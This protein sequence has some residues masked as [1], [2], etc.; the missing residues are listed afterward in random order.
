MK[1]HVVVRLGDADNY[2]PAIGSHEPCLTV[3]INQPQ[4]P[5]LVGT[6]LFSVFKTYMDDSPRGTVA[7]LLSLAI[8]VYT[9]DLRISRG[10][11]LDRWTRELVLH[12]PVVDQSKWEHAVTAVQNMLGFLTGDSW[13]IELRERKETP[14]GT[15]K[16]LDIDGVCLFSGGA[17][18]LV[19][20]IDGLSQG[21][22]LALVGH[23]G[24]GMTNSF[25]QSTL[26]FLKK[27]YPDKIHPF[28]FYLQPPKNMKKSKTQETNPAFGM[29]GEN[30]M[31]SRSILFLALGVAVAE[32]AKNKQTL[33]VAENGLISLNVPLTNPRMGSL[34][35]RTTHP[36]FI[37]LF[38]SLLQKLHLRSTIEMPYQFKTKGE[39]FKEIGDQKVLQ[40]TLPL[41]MSCSHPEAGRYRGTFGKHCG[42]CVPC[43]IR[44]SAATAAKVADAQYTIDVRVNPP[45]WQTQ[46]GRDL[47]AFGMALERMKE[48]EPWDIFSDVMSTG[49]LPPQHI[50][51]YVAVFQRGMNE[52]ASFLT[53]KKIGCN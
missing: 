45:S 49:P 35:T 5:W 4:D 47:R 25:Q 38:R 29:E 1:W 18:S 33:M 23:H 27:R 15:T 21:K 24:A 39:M 32:G 13:M 46:S 44:R 34:S 53:S 50:K 37:N 36:F 43:I 7:D 8:G 26:E 22:S 31:R 11:G 19:G 52:V 20:A 17:D 6:N 16:L 14:Q 12:L 10:Y 48:K 40:E 51:D 28:M 41:T 9:A 30:T 42:Y 2:Q 3:P